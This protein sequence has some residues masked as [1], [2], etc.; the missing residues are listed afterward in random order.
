MLRSTKLLVGLALVL[1]VPLAA[2]AA[3]ATARFKLR[4]D[5]QEVIITA[6]GTSVDVDPDTVG[7]GFK[8]AAVVAAVVSGQNV[9]VLVRYHRTARGTFVDLVF[10]DS[11]GGLTTAIG[12]MNLSTAAPGHP[13]P[14]DDATDA[15]AITAGG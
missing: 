7:G 8:R 4:G 1:V 9:K 13:S 15:S 5:P 11:I 14:E 10:S 2:I 12:T 3:E 6:S